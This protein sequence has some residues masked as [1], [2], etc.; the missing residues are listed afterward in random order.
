[1]MKRLTTVVLALTAG[2]FLAALSF[3]TQ[4]AMAYDGPSCPTKIDDCGWWIP[5]DPVCIDGDCWY[6]EIPL[7][8]DPSQ[9]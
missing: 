2:G 7:M 5:P 9:T 8:G 6:P 3:D 4:P 1:M